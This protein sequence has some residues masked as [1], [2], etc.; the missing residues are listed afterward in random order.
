M[1]ARGRRR[2]W[3]DLHK[4]CCSQFTPQCAE[5]WQ[6]KADLEARGASG[7]GASEVLL[8]ACITWALSARSGSHCW[9][10]GTQDNADASQPAAAASQEAGT[11]SKKPR[12]EPAPQP[13]AQAHS[14]SSNRAGGS[15]ERASQAHGD[16]L[17]HGSASNGLSR[18]AGATSHDSTTAGRRT[19]PSG[20]HAQAPAG[21]ASAKQQ[22]SAPSPNEELRQLKEKIAA[23]QAHIQRE[24]VAQHLARFPN[25]HLP[26]GAETHSRCWCGSTAAQYVALQGRHSELQCFHSGALQYFLSISHYVGFG[27][28][29]SMCPEIQYSVCSVTMQL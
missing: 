28:A 27:V 15:K 18:P 22:G 24:Q 11:D 23:R 8:H 5:A 16:L 21:R 6:A 26:F 19:G 29:G 25:M 7:T 2:R 10:L 13:H 20:L 12:R 17:G 14:P 3:E 4:R 9:S 1:A